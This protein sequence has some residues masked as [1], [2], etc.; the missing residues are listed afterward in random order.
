MRNDLQDENPDVYTLEEQ[1][2]DAHTQLVPAEEVI[3]DREW[4][5]ANVGTGVR[6][7]RWHFEHEGRTF[8]LYAADQAAACDIISAHLGKPSG[9][10]PGPQESGY[11]CYVTNTI[12][13]AKDGPTSF[14]DCR[15]SGGGSR[16]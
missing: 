1:A 8:V 3:K 14:L 4:Y 9:S 5:E 13:G 15:K 7:P 16:G 2:D 11:Y 10:I 6:S 12:V